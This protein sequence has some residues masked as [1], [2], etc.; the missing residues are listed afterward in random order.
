MK[1]TL[2]PRFVGSECVFSNLVGMITDFGLW[3]FVGFVAFH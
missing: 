1:S 2:F 3:L